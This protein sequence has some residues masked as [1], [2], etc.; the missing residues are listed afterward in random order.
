[1]WK[2]T[3]CPDFSPTSFTFALVIILIVVYIVTLI[4]SGVKYGELNKFFFLGATF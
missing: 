2:Y 4:A 1:M 3:C